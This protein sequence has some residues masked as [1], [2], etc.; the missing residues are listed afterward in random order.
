MDGHELALDYVFAP[1]APDDGVTVRVPLSLLNQ[2]D[3]APFSWQVPG[4]RLELA[5]EL[6]R[7]LPKA[8]RRHFAPAPEFARRALDWLAAHPADRPETL[9]A[10]L[11]R[12]LRTL[13]GELVDADRLGPRRRCRTTCGSAS[14]SGR[15][16]RP[17]PNR[18]P[19]AR[20]SAAL[21]AE[22]APRL[23]RTLAAAASALTRTGA[24]RWKFGTIP[25][26]CSC[27]ATATRSSA[28]RRWST[29]AP[30]SG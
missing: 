9:P 14:P 20:T 30:R 25:S 7:S 16:T 2:L 12:A 13:T 4:L 3:P 19:P 10:A 5:T 21:Q 11:G 18:W 29:R 22:L 17:T 23:N 1:G 15:T 28:T 6:I 8:V 24:T 26:R 27:P